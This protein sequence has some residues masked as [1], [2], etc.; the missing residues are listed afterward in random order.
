MPKTFTHTFD[1]PA[2]KGTATVNTGLFIGGKW[3][4]PVD[5]ASID[6]INPATGKAIATISLASSKDIDIAVDVAKKAKIIKAYK[7]SWGL[8]AP[9]SVR[10][11]LL[12]KL[13]DLLEK[14]SDEFAA[15]ESLNT[16]KI[17]A[18]AKADDVGG[19]ISCIRYFAGWAD[20][21]QGRTIET[22]STKL[23]YS[24][25]EPYGVVGQIIPWNYP[26]MMLSWKISPA[27]A[28]GNA[29][30]LKPSEV[31][32][33]TA[34]RICDLVNEAGFPPGVLNIVNGFGPTVGQAIAVHPLI[35]KIAFTGSTLTGRKILKASAESNL[36]DVTLELGGKSPTIIFDDADVEQALKWA[37]HGIFY[38]MGQSC[39]AGSRIFVQEGIYDTF[40]AK[41]SAIAK[42]VG[43]AA[44]DPFDEGTK[45]GPQVSSTQ[46]DR[47]MAYID[48][49]K[50]EGATVHTGGE[51]GGG[52]GYFIQ[53]TIITDV[54]PE[55]KVVQEEIFGPVAVLIKFKTEEEVIES[56]NNTTFGLASHVFSENLGRAL[57]VAHAL[58]AGTAWVNLSQVPEVAVPFGGYKQSG[59]GR[60]MG[61]YA[62]NTYTQVK[63]VHVN[64]ELKL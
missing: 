32:P 38:N 22:N 49:G 8:K 35:E 27:L 9:G 48:S 26:L 14:H 61:E 11:K 28:T 39:T 43:S 3:V 20:K 47:V 6:V 62:V 52:E 46:F 59:I 30:V 33:L 40:L 17:F 56:A 29:I 2:F 25:H 23:T 12:N 16:G 34:L 54:K 10:A 19:A 53:P 51:P 31:T 13:A 1:T 21:V 60:E 63:G 41:F 36:K 24:R 42:S 45:H 50:Q 58:E 55:M 7:T 5:P 37:S 18:T 4:D 15:L 44:G 64:L 57:R